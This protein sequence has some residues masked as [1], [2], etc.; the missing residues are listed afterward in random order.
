M[1][2][3][4]IFFGFN[5]PRGHKRG[6]ENVIDIQAKALPEGTRK[7][8][9]FFDRSSSVSRWDDVIA[10]GVRLGP[11]RFIVVNILVAKLRRRLRRKKC[12]LIMHSHNY[13][14]SL[15]LWWKCDLFSVHDGLGY[16]NKAVGRLIPSLFYLVEACV[17]RRSS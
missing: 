9:I 12:D 4:I 7:Y 1:R 11:L 16:H 8:Y 2:R 5:N 14:V 3:V 17:Y 6:V 15:F 10:L 13:L